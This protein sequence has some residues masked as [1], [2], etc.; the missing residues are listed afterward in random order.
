MSARES[1]IA[2]LLREREAMA[3]HSKAD[4]VAAIDAELERVGAPVPKAAKAV[5]DDAPKPVKR[6]TTRKG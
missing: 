5:A 6:T 4:R 1:Y 2:A 3:T